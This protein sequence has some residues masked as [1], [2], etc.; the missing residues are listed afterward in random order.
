MTTTRESLL[1]FASL[2]E[3]L[4][5]LIWEAYGRA[6]YYKPFEGSTALVFPPLW[7]HEHERVYKVQLTSY[8]LG[9]ERHHEWVGP[10][11]EPVLDALEADLRRWELEDRVKD[12]KDPT[13]E[14][15]VAIRED[16]VAR[17]P[18][19]PLVRVEGAEDRRKVRLA[20]RRS[21][22]AGWPRIS[23]RSRGPR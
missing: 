22:T 17:L 16:E 3:R 4:H 12:L 9:Q 5:K 13:L 2:Q 1:R 6:S 19:R 20:M 15:H 8:L 14:V 18:P 10:E 23:P 11:L 7:G 21:S